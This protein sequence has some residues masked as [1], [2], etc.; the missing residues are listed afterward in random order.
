MSHRV[1][2]EPVRLT[3]SS[4][5]GPMPLGAHGT[6][7]EQYLLG[8]MNTSRMTSAMS[9]HAVDLARLQRSGVVIQNATGEV[10]DHNPAA[11]IVLQMTSDQ[12]LGRTSLDPS[13]AAVLPDLQPLSGDDHPAMKVLSTG[14][15]V[16]GFVMGV[17]T[18]TAVYRWLQ[19][20]S[21]PIR[22]DDGSSGAL[23]QFADITVAIEARE[24][25]Q[26]AMDH[27]QHNVLPPRAVD[28][29][30]MSVW[31]RYR[32][33]TAPL[34]VGGDFCGVYPIDDQ[35]HGFFIG[36]ACGHDIDTVSTTM[37]A[38]HTLRAAGI[39]LTRPGRVLAW[40]DDTL[41]AT[42]GAVY[43][44]AIHGTL[45][46]EGDGPANI[47]LANAGHPRPIHVHRDGVS[48]I[49]SAGTLAGAV[50][51]FDEPPTVT[52]ELALGDEIV[53]YTDGLTD[54]LSP[55]ISDSELAALLETES[56]SGGSSMDVIDKLM[57][58]DHRSARSDDT[59][60][61]VMRRHRPSER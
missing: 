4:C 56:R 2:Q 35:R 17:R 26:S 14:L 6:P 43:C 22:L 1:A 19:V 23:T 16:E 45:A 20:D 9:V 28:I 44:S 51:E 3:A 11:L 47:E 61:L 53:F 13:W 18:G 7:C 29:A 60:V 31:T 32:A 12:L 10:I 39:H 49:E 8:E 21:W 55:R 48:V 52:V 59:A 57:N 33:V 42:P 36:D 41:K 25:M 46:V 38:H 24:A 37:V 40:L 27:L 34:Q 30:G 15:A 58:I 50:D 5:P 54:S